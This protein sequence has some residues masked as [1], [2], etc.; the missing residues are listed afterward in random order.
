MLRHQDRPA[1]ARLLRPALWL[2]AALMMPALS[3][4]QSAP[5]LTCDDGSSATPCGFGWDGV[6]IQKVPAIFKFQA[7]I[8]QSKLPVGDGMFSQVWVK[9]LS[10]GT[11]VCVEAFTDV[12]V[13]DSVLNLTI[14]AGDVPASCDLQQVIAESGDLQFQVCLGSLGTCLTPVSLGTA[15]YAVKSSYAA[16]AQQAA[17]ADV[18]GIASFAHRVT[19]DASMFLRKTLGVGYFD[20]ETPRDT[21]WDTTVPAEVPQGKYADSAFLLWKPVRTAAARFLHMGARTA[22]GMVGYLDE[23]VLLARGVVA[24]GTVVVKGETASGGVLQPGAPALVVEHGD[25]TVGG[26]HLS[27][28]GNASVA[29][30]RLDLQDIVVRRI[31]DAGKL[32]LQVASGA[33][34]LGDLAVTGRADIDLDATVGGSLIVGNGATVQAG[35]LTLK[36]GQL[37]TVNGVPVQSNADIVSGTGIFRSATGIMTLDA[38][39]VRV[40]QSLSVEQNTDFA[41]M[42]TVDGVPLH[43]ALSTAAEQGGGVVDPNAVH[44]TLAGDQ[45]TD[46]VSIPGLLT[47]GQA[48]IFGELH[49]DAVNS[50]ALWIEGWEVITQSR[51]LFVEFVHAFEA[52]FQGWVQVEGGVRMNEL[53][54]GGGGVGDPGGAEAYIHFDG[55]VEARRFTIKDVGEVIDQERNV[56]GNEGIFSGTV[57][58]TWANFSDTLT[59]GSIS[60]NTVTATGDAGWVTAPGVIG[61]VQ[62]RQLQIGGSLLGNL[63]N[64]TTAYI[65]HD[66]HVQANRFS[67][68]NN[69]AHI[70]AAGTA[71]FN[72]TVTQGCRPGYGI[73]TPVLCAKKGGEADYATAAQACM[74]DSAHLCTHAEY[75][76]IKNKD[77]QQGA[78]SGWIGDSRTFMVFSDKSAWFAFF[79]FFDDAGISD[80]FFEVTYVG[81]FYCCHSK[82]VH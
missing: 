39:E 81:Q 15:P 72:G 22:D 4:A 64:G 58:A 7:R 34:V 28:S 60:G 12:L 23:L 68:W 70:S 62:A 52:T 25:V 47:A 54:I 9:A 55:N 32:M 19:A 35:A 5:E 41:N 78:N 76:Y 73:D 77:G 36:S 45:K 18:A 37:N 8:A 14:G 30:G 80:T 65:H 16:R 71:T 6:T 53:Q 40:Q 48:E 27:V 42:P 10:G 50:R 46:D 57:A 44:F 49:A 56:F 24:R 63:D 75:D 29:G 21:D 59:A 43:I 69:S 13:R 20:F 3:A 26:G 11:T 51:E 38:I 33:K 17:R 67:T 31:L 66:G 1:G 2:L 74:E 61:G 79:A 82:G